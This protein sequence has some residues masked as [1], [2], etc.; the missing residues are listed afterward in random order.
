LTQIK[1][2]ERRLITCSAIEME[3]LRYSE[4]SELSSDPC[5]LRYR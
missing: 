3:P 1:P 2:R 4:C 5:E